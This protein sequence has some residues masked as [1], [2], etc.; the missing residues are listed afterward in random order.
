MLDQTS[1]TIT[2]Y[3]NAKKTAV[4]DKITFKIED[5]YSI[6][7]YNGYING[8]WILMEYDAKKDKLF[9]VFEKEMAKGD[10]EFKIEVKDGRGNIGV[11][12]K[13]YRLQ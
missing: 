11:F 5:D 3:K 4:K 9:H 1:P 10:F 12:E 13:V 7:S 2:P 6:S 8:E